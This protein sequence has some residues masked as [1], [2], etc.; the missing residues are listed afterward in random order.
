[1]TIQPDNSGGV[2]SWCRRGQKVVCLHRGAWRDCIFGEAG[3]SFDQVLTIRSVRASFAT[4]GGLDLLFEEIV[5]PAKLYAEGVME[6]GF[7]HSRFRPLV[8]RTQDQ[9]VARFR[10]HLRTK[11]KTG[12]VE[13]P[14]YGE[15]S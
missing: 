11:R 5:N 8:T 1:M 10:K 7:H 12:S 3:P 13:I 9:D 6:A 14:H 2:P 4:I 15:V